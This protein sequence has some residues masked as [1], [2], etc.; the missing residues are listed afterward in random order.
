[1]IKNDGKIKKKKLIELLEDE[2]LID[3][4]LSAAAKHSRLKAL[5]NPL[6][7]SDDSPLVKVDYLGRHSNV[8]ITQQGRN[9]LR[10]FG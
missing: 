9:T 1:M 7:N 2:Q 8:I 5:L 3:Y 10:I 4:S 6:V